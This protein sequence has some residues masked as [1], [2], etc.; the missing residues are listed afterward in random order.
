MVIIAAAAYKAA[1]KSVILRSRALKIYN[2][3]IL[4][5]KACAAV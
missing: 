1:R 2:C 3:R 4:I 5:F